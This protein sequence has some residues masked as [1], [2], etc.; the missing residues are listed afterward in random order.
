MLYLKIDAA[1]LCLYVVGSPAMNT[2][3]LVICIAGIC[4]ILVSWLVVKRDLFVKVGIDVFAYLFIIF[5]F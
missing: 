3:G 5:E 2:L 4:S 1:L